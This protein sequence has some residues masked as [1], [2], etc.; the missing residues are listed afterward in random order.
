MPKEIPFF[1]GGLGVHR[2]PP[3]TLMKSL[4]KKL[5]RVQGR[6][7]KR[8]L[9]FSTINYRMILPFGELFIP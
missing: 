7:L 4:G 2:C 6:V 3:K 9:L 8:W 1:W 5:Y